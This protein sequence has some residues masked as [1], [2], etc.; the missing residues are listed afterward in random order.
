MFL[1][2]PAGFL[3]SDQGGGDPVPPETSCRGGPC[4]GVGGAGGGLPEMSSLT[5]AQQYSLKA[6]YAAATGGPPPTPL[7]SME[8]G[9]GTA[10][11]RGGFLSEYQV[12]T[13]LCLLNILFL[14]CVCIP[15]SMRKKSFQKLP[16]NNHQASVGTLSRSDHISPDSFVNTGCGLM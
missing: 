1:T 3:G 16:L 13:C 6:K 8:Q 14:I 2:F 7:P 12:N 5:P 9:P 10:R 4:R 15:L 11:R